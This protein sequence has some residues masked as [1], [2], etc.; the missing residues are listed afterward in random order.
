MSITARMSKT[1]CAV[2]HAP[3]RG[4]AACGKLD[5]L[6]WSVSAPP[7]DGSRS[8]YEQNDKALLIHFKSRLIPIKQRS[9]KACYALPS[10]QASGRSRLTVT[11]NRIQ[12]RRAAASTAGTRN[13][14]NAAATRPRDITIAPVK[15]VTEVRQRIRDMVTSFSACGIKEG[16]V[17]PG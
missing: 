9:A 11:L 8:N 12:V 7:D 5:S 17:Q 13:I 14:K 4:L 3:A 15:I 2:S 10:N 6:R 1:G 16:R